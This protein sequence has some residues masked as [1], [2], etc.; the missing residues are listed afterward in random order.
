MARRIINL[1][2]ADKGNGDPIRT[3]FGKINDN[4]AELYA[5]LSGGSGANI[6]E[7]D[8]K[9]SVFADDSTVIVDAVSNKL[10]A[11]SAELG[12]I[13]ITGSTVSTSDSS[14]ITVN[15]V[16]NLNSDVNIGGNLIPN[17]ANGGDLG[18]LTRPWR[19]LYVSQST[20][21]LG[22]VSLSLDANNNLTVN[23]SRVGT[24][25][26]A[27]LS[28]KPTSFSSLVNGSKTVSLGSNG[29]LTLPSQPNLLTNVNQIFTTKIYKDAKTPTPTPAEITTAYD[30]WIGEQEVYNAIR[31]ED[32]SSIAPA[33]RSWAGLPPWEA[34]PLIVGFTGPGLPPTNSLATAAQSAINAYL[35][36]KELVSNLEIVNGNQTISF[37]NTGNLILPS[38]VSM[39]GKLSLGP[40][41]GGIHANQSTGII[42]IGD[43][44]D[45]DTGYG[46]A[47]STTIAIGGAANVFQISTYGPPAK[48][49]TFGK[50]GN[51]QIPGN[52]QISGDIRSEREIN[53]DINL[54]DSTLRRWRFGED[55]DTVFPTNISINYSGGNVQFPR[56]IADS[57]KA[58]SV[59]GQGNTGSAALSWTVD[60]DAASQYAAVG[61]SKGGGDNL[62]KVVLQAQSNSGDGATVK[63]WKF[64][65]T[66]ALTI[67]GDIRSEGNINIDINLSDSTLRRWRF[68]ED[69][70]LTLP[71]VGKINNGAYDWTFGSTGI[72]TF[73]GVINAGNI[74]NLVVNDLGGGTSLTAGSQVQIG[75]SAGIAGAGVLIKNA[76]TN[77]LSGVTSLEEGS[78]IQMD[79]GNVSLFGYTYNSAGG[80]DG[81]EN[82][83]VVEVDNSN[84]NKG[85]RIG[86]RIINTIG[87]ST[88]NVFQGVTISQY[89][90]L[91]FP[92]NT[93]QSTA[94]TGFS[95]AADD[96][97]QRLIN[98]GELVKFIGAGGI[99]TASDAEGNITITGS[100]VI[101]EW[102]VTNGTS[103]YSF[104]LPSDGTYVMW[105][106]GNI[107][108]G[109]ITWNATASV[110]NTNVPAIGSQYAWNYTGGG[111]PIL[112]TAIPDQIR[113]SAGTISTDATYA[114]TTSNRFDFGISNTSGANQTVYYGYT[115]I[116]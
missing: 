71:S 21:Y 26:Y 33:T 110:T 115:K 74:N 52:L 44:I 107:A 17:I 105:V 55:G 46:L 70:I 65:E 88:T 49:W 8:I 25:S 3:A 91:T 40:T 102:L 1:G 6:I 109:I 10:F 22:G 47:P 101:G 100:K 84:L 87:G 67:P 18:S 61:V 77:T 29:T 56:I 35:S 106:K 113:G 5:I 19:S 38:T 23:G 63:L 69:G 32:A 66:G 37:E 54:S 53:I 83:L 62:A 72:T 108:N 95:V 86:T 57:G 12:N 28:D 36:W 79:N 81:L 13:E 59:Q 68:G 7:T 114:G 4:F 11:N 34:Y 92:D 116:S 45:A 111:S 80:G 24:T 43:Y 78:K 112:L 64:D 39:N 93:V 27:D 98:A 60:P 2:T 94:W 85:V 9:G 16:I 73:P 31:N 42:S 58:F 82:Q 104:T 76:V 30:N 99:T 48:T 51:L 14:G 41:L 20:I 75:N 15:Q 103:T 97:T 96:S 50:D 89:G 90:E